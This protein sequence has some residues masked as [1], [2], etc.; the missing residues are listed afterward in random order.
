MQNFEKLGA[1]YLGKRFDPAKHETTEELTLYDA[2]DLTTH[3]VIIGMTGSGKTG[4]GIG[5]IEEAALDH[6]P[7][8][9]IDP[10]GDI[11]NL[12]LTFPDLSPS[13]F[14]PWVDP[15]AAA[16]AGETVGSF[17]GSTA[18]L[19]RDGL[20]E[21]GQDGSR[22]GRLRD[23]AEMTLYTPGSSAG[24]PL[25]V[26]KE[27]G[28]PEATDPDSLREKLESTVQNILTL[29][30]IEA[31]PL[32]SREHILMSNILNAAWI[33]GDSLDLAALI[34]AIQTPGI[35]RI[36]V[37]DLDSFYPPKDRFALA[38]RLNNLLAAPGF[39]IW[40]RGDPLD[41]DRLLYTPAGGPRISIMS[42]AHL[43][44][45][46]RMFFVTALLNELISWMRKQ[47]GSPALRAI[48]YM[49]E[50][51]GYLPP[52]ANPASKQPF[53]TLLKQ[54]RAY[55]IGLVLATQN[56]VDLDYKGLSNTGTWFIGRLQTERDIDRVRDGL[57]SAAGSE[58]LDLARIERTLADIPK[59]CF[60]LH[61]VHDRAPDLFQTRWVMSYLAGPLTTEQIKLLQ[62]D[63]VDEA[64]PAT[65]TSPG[66]QARATETGATRP[67]LDPAIDQFFIPA[68]AEAAIGEALVYVPHLIAATRT[69][70]VRARP[71]VNATREL[72]LAVPASDGP[73]GIDWDAAFELDIDIGEIGSE[74]FAEASYAEC[75]ASLSTPK[76]I[77]A[78]ESSLKR[79]IRNEKP[80]VLYKSDAMD[81][82]S[83]ADESERDFRIR[84][85]QLGN[86][87]RDREAAALKRRYE[88]RVQTL[89]NRLLRAEQAVAR[90]AEQ[91]RG[92]QIDTA[93]SFGTAVLGAILGRKIVSSTSATRIGSAVRKAGKLG[94]QSGDVRRAEEVVASVRQE[95]ADLE[96][97]FDDDVAA[98]EGAYDAS[99][100]ALSETVIRPQL[101]NIEMRICGVGWVPF[102]RDAAGRLHAASNS[103]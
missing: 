11:G 61:N 36:G 67:I 50:I 54:A 99:V 103:R 41:I 40:S 8:I 37:M 44:D 78:C 74:P 86:E 73:L 101:S 7:V 42:I 76:E 47:P 70:Y 66:P 77:A 45:K 16:E 34:H 1:F 59:R 83:T 75:A 87:K 35:D 30:D 3:A 92:H 25:S 15:G 72:V 51:F 48:L 14:E 33:R 85:Q 19:W 53:L 18:K 98:L 71:S 13:D 46:E 89:R 65:K 84:L 20:A 102:Y 96:Q 27:F 94:Q 26:L 17:A 55:G 29:L 58:N 60:L 28:P 43:G 39:E 49:D 100:D 24:K 93:L 81:E 91:A 9:A 57:Q 69:S 38:M 22:I 88:Q 63:T 52:V 64:V 62:A 2:K 80:L 6:I 56:P 95:L 21:W 4:L 82:Y 31:D 32:T 97:R 10:K 68:T 12:L 23:S 5:L 90:E 79:W